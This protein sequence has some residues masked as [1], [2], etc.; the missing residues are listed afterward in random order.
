MARAALGWGVRELAE[1]TGLTAN[2]IS[3]FETMGG[4]LASTVN[5][6]QMALEKAGVV[7]IAKD[8]EGGVGVR[9]VS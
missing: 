1:K 4:G 2:T 5:A 8:A 6:I 3:R 9:L 7:F